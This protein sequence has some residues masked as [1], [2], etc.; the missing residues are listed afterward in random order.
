[1]AHLTLVVDN[2]TSSSFSAEREWERVYEQ[3]FVDGL[4]T[5]LT[6]SNVGPASISCH[7]SR[8]KGEVFIVSYGDEDEEWFEVEDYGTRWEVFLNLKEWLGDVEVY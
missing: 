3:L 1:M 5:W 4:H 7:S 8:V 6:A 2:T